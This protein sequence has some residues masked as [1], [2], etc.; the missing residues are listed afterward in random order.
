MET[1]SMLT[2]GIVL[3]LLLLSCLA[4]GCWNAHVGSRQ[5]RSGHPR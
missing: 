1:A 4:L 3:W 2:A 5:R